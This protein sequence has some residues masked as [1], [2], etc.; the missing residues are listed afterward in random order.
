MACSQMRQMGIQLFNY[1][2]LEQEAAQLKGKRGMAIYVLARAWKFAFVLSW[3][4]NDLRESRA[5]RHITCD[6]MTA[7][8]PESRVRAYPS[9]PT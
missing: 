8:Q 3:V 9:S 1:S 2:S 6:V 7:A 4:T 5:H